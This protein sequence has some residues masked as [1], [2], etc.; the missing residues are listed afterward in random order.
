[1]NQLK[2]YS[3]I[4]WMALGPVAFVYLLRTALAEIAHKPQTETRIQWIVFLV[5]AFPIALGLF[6][7]GWYA[8]RGEYDHIPETSA[9]LED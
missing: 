9:E 1:M 4:L 3:G 6:L 5:V 8:L 2:R 7:F